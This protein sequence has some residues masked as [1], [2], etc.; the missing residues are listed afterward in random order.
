M[1]ETSLVFKEIFPYGPSNLFS[2][3]YLQF[4]T[5]MHNVTTCPSAGHVGTLHGVVTHLSYS[6]A[7]IPL[8]I[9]VFSLLL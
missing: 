9:I 1:L 8:S 3:K 2:N 6:N 7:N 4:F 5:T